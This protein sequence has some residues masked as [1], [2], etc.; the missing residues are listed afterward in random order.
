MIQEN[1]IFD[2][3]ETNTLPTENKLFENAETYIY[4]INW[5]AFWL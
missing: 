2:V 5:K 3:W 4:T 1:E